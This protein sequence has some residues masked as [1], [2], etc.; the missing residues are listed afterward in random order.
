MLNKL[1]LPAVYFTDA[2]MLYYA[3][4]RAVRANTAGN[5]NVQCL[6]DREVAKM[7]HSW[8][9]VLMVLLLFPFASPNVCV[10]F[11][12]DLHHPRYQ[13]QKRTNAAGQID[14]E[15][16]VKPLEIAGETLTLVAA[17]FTTSD[18]L[19]TTQGDRYRLGFYLREDEPRITIKARDYNKFPNGYHYWML[20]ARMQYARGFQEFTWDASVIRGLGMQLEDFGAVA[21]IGGA[22]YFVV[23]PVLLHVA[24]FPS[25]IR[26]QGCRFIFVPNETMTVTYR[27]APR[28]PSRP[29]VLQPSPATWYKD[30][31]HAITWDGKDRQG[32]PAAEG[33]YVLNLTA[34][35][36]PAGSP[37]E[38]IPFD[39]EFYYQ[40]EITFSR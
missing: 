14:R 32:R 16:G 40:P 5:F 21:S 4:T 13:F 23:A 29:P 2:R 39:V 3:V 34:T 28:E 31:R 12:Q 35:V 27:L 36:T 1:I 8:V 37:P 18:L 19:G 24:P 9:A 7:S 30:T 22:G 6:W 38:K 15:E 10:V 25:R 20:P 26:V 17:H 11:A 33:F